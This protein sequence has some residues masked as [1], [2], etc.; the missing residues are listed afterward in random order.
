M[1]ESQLLWALRRI[2]TDP[3]KPRDEMRAIA[4]KAIDDYTASAREESAQ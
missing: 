2:A 3:V 4:Q 1:T